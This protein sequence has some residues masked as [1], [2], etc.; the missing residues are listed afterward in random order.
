MA[1]LQ[2]ESPIPLVRVNS[3]PAAGGGFFS[4][5]SLNQP[6]QSQTVGRLQQ[7][8]QEGHLRGLQSFQKHELG[9]VSE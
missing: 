8:C 3:A 6:Q 4:S 9:E 5:S 2:R 1:S 7:Q